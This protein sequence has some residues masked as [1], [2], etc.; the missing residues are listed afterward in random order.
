MSVLR[1]EL[2]RRL[3]RDTVNVPKC[4]LATDVF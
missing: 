3:R 1:N 4:G 2:T